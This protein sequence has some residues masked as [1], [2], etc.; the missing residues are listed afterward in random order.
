MSAIHA[1][2]DEFDLFAAVS[3]ALLAER[4]LLKR[5]DTK[6]LVSAK[7]LQRMLGALPDHYGLLRAGGN[8]L[9]KYET[10]YFDS[11]EL[12]CFH[13][14]RVGRRPR[15]KV[16][17]RHYLDRGLSYLEVKTKNNH[18]RTLKT[19][20][21]REYRL[22][23]LNA[24]DHGFVSDHSRMDGSEM[25]AQLWTNFSRITLVGLHSHERVTID[26]D[27]EF[28]RADNVQRLPGV[29][30][31]EVKQARYSACTPVMRALRHYRFRPARA[32]K[33]CTAIAL[34]RNDVRINR[35]LPALK[36]MEALNAK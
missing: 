28:R 31:V 34:L 29:A 32:S 7:V 24:A 16:R 25:W 36:T 4:K 12:G 35:F 26:T 30:I 18:N 23:H 5:T 20:V 11:P 17:V 21:Q 6:F 1:A 15:H 14:H 13:D 9:A 2:V 10:L 27:L 19:R 3:P 22:N 33:Y 8:P